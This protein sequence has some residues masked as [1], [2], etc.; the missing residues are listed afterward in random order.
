MAKVAMPTEDVLIKSRF[1][2]E[3]R[4]M[5][6]RLDAYTKK[7]WHEMIETQDILSKNTVK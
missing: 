7:R 2:Y 4:R 1:E 3:A 5:Q 6:L